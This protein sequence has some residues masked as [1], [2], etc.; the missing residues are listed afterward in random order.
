VTA[1]EN[2]RLVLHTVSAETPTGRAARQAAEDV[3]RLE[4]VRAAGK[5]VLQFEYPN[6]GMEEAHVSPRGR[7][8]WR[9]FRRLVEDSR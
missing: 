5:L 9:S 7:A 1:R 2:A 8:L 3:L 6:T 4:N